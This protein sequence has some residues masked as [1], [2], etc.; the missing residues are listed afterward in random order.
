VL[1]EIPFDFAYVRPVHY[2]LVPEEERARRVAVNDDICVIDDN[3]HLVRGIMKIRITDLP[4][5]FFGWGFWAAISPHSFERYRELYD[6]D[7]T[8]EPPFRGLL[9]VSPPNYPDLLDAEVS[10]QLGT[11]SQRPEFRPTHFD[12]P[13][14]VEYRDGITVQ[15]WHRIVAEIDEYQRGLA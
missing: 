11:L 14:F 1:E 6:V 5:R 8:G 9:A 7:G 4:G 15:R 12:H 3:M 13:L 10:V 2:F